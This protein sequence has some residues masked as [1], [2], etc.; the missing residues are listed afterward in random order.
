MYMHFFP[1]MFA[2]YAALS[3]SQIVA[4]R[5]YYSQSQSEKL[6]IPLYTSGFV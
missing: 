4:A 5:H 3:A 2:I 6:R 1:S